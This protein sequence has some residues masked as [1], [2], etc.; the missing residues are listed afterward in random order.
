MYCRVQMLR[1]VG[2]R[3][4]DGDTG[5]VCEGILTV[6]SAGSGLRARLVPPLAMAPIAELYGVHLIAVR[7]GKLVLRGFERANQQAVLQDWVC[8]PIDT[9]H[10]F[11]AGG[12]PLGAPLFPDYAADNNR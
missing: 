9:R 7:E 6:A 1:R 10:G 2:V 4:R 8:T 11:D 12:R 5:P 3:I